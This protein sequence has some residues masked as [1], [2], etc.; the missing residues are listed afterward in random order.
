MPEDMQF[1]IGWMP[2]QLE[3]WGKFPLSHEQSPPQSPSQIPD[4][5]GKD[6]LYYYVI[7]L[8]AEVTCLPTPILL[9]HE[10]QY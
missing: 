4:C 1:I 10:Y 2:P 3:V 8:Q 5:R 9:G 6:T 7:G